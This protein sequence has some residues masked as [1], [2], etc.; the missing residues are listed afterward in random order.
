MG[1]KILIGLGS[2]ILLL[3]IGVF[4]GGYFLL[5]S[6][7]MEKVKTEM[8]SLVKKGTGREFSLGKIGIDAGFSP[9]I[10]IE[11][12][13]ISN[14]EWAKNKNL[15]VIKEA[16]VSFD[17]LPLLHK[18]LNV[19][20]VTFSGVDAAL[21]V[22]KQG[23]KSWDMKTS[24][25]EQKQA[26]KEASSKFGIAFDGIT[27]KDVNIIY[28]DQA[29]GTEEII[30]ISTLDMKAN[31]D[32]SL[33]AK[34]VRGDAAYT[35]QASAQSLD[36]LLEG[37][38]LKLALDGNGTKGSAKLKIDGTAANVTKDASF[39]G[40]LIASADSLSDFGAFSGSPLPSSE[41]I[42]LDTKVKGNAQRVTLSD[43]T[44]GV[45]NKK[46]TGSLVADL[47]GKKPS[48]TGDLNLPQLAL[49]AAKTA[50]GD[51]PAVSTADK[52][53]RV[54][55]NI[56]FPTDALAA[57]N[58]D[59]KLTIGALALPDYTLTDI[60]LPVKLQNAQLSIAPFAFKL[61]GKS[62][63][64]ST[65][66]S[67]SGAG[68]NIS[69]SGVPL[70]AIMKKGPLNGGAITFNL[71]T[72]GQGKDLHAVL[73]TLAGNASF[74]VKDATYTP[75]SSKTA[76]LL[77]VLSG[78][79]GSGAVL[80]SCAASNFNI[81]GGVANSTVLVADSSAARVDGSGSINLGSE[82]LQ[83]TLKPTPKAAGLNQLAIPLRVSGTFASPSVLP[84]PQG[85]ALAAAQIGLG[86]SKNADLNALG[87]LLGQTSPSASSAV[88][89]NSPCF[90]AP[91][92]SVTGGGAAP[93][94]KD[95][96][97]EQ[98]NKVR[99]IRDSVKGLKD[100]F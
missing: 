99:N 27:G 18:E 40:R 95:T 61:D 54:I 31:P 72:N 6:M 79:Q 85:T 17:I 10:T 16:K 36:R 52:S 43:L 89:Q 74:F 32:F 30:T 8:V 45:G 91:P 66:L 82:K 75:S 96:F 50:A 44:A 63:T 98:E 93:T 87:S 4:A 23:A 86:F 92:A 67:P 70:N 5:Q 34:L 58:A 57:A 88:T 53:G 24:E 26:S 42:A 37:A 81:A 68:F 84:D 14:P 3:V 80:L 62:I 46:G 25:A 64:G 19:N 51:K 33:N 22:S 59:V 28:N 47:S 90:S 56:V 35:I 55:P 76:D 69:G 49:G 38:P 48:I 9:T 1:K 71:K 73:A 39:D 100:L 65:S 77:K 97:K 78:G 94:L 20:E 2:I 7:D 60:T 11:N 21:E 13:S 15:L 41:A 29:K 83:M 12:A